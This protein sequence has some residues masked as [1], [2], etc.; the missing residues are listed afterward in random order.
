MNVITQLNRLSKKA[1]RKLRLISLYNLISFWLTAGV[2]IPLIFLFI[3]LMPEEELTFQVLGLIF[4]IPAILIGVSYL[5]LHINLKLL[6]GSVNAY[7]ILLGLFAIQCVGIEIPNWH[8]NFQFGL[9][10]SFSF[11]S[12]DFLFKINI[13]AIVFTIYLIS[14]QKDLPGLLQ[15]LKLNS[16]KA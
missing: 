16:S 2:S 11:S 14:L 1:P 3:G 4:L 10:V 12:G 7:W 8:F 13:L 6:R 15:E 9:P 5:M